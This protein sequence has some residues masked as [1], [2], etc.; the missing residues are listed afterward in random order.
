MSLFQCLKLAL[1][2]ISG[3]KMRSFLTMLGVIIGIAAVITLVSVVQGF[4]NDMVS[5]FNSM[6]TN[7][8]TVSLS[9][10]GG[11]MNVKPEDMLQV[12]DDNRDL[13]SNVSPTVTIMNA[14]AKYGS[15]NTYTSV[16]GGNEEYGIIKDYAVSSG[17]FISYIDTTNRNCVCVIGTYIANEFFGGTDPIGKILKINGSAY[18][19]IGVLEEEGDSTETSTDNMVIIPYSVAARLARNGRITSY[20]FVA[21]DSESIEPAKK[22]LE[23]F[24]YDIFEDEDAYSVSNLSELVD[25]IE[26]LMGSLSAVLAGIAAISLLV[27]G[28]GIMNIM[29]VSVTERT[30]EIGIRKAIGGKR[31]DILAQFVI[32]AIITSGIGGVI[33]IIV[34]ALMS[35]VLAKLLGVSSGISVSAVLLSFSVSVLIGILFGY[36]PAAKASKLNPIDALRHD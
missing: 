13:F 19:V 21:V 23:D 11:N 8:I 25:T 30:R 27:G 29:L 31:R 6:G 18:T 10:R 32:E 14:T 26:E 9:G 3:N 4:S 2:S 24:L 17:R 34:G 7:N 5:S 35:S 22:V 1:K 15:T 33:G 16:Y 20:T 12:A 36:F 28:I